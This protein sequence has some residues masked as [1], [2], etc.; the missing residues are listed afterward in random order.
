M[1][2]VTQKE[3]EG[4]FLRYSKAVRRAGIHD[5]VELHE[6]SKVN[7]RAFRA[8]TKKSH[9]SGLWG[10]PGTDNGFLGWTKA[11]AHHTLST[12]ARTLEDLKYYQMDSNIPSEQ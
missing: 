1:N 12:M 6:G 11:E 8:Y 3:L 4:A 5:E 7:G 2:R 10:A 9:G